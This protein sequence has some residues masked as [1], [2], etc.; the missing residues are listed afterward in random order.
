[1]TATLPLIQH[2]EGGWELEE[3]D[4]DP[5]TGR[6]RFEYSRQ[7]PKQLEERTFEVRCQPTLPTHLGWKQL[8]FLEQDVFGM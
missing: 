6:A 8:W 2:G 3:M 1:M 5:E 4:W 7:V